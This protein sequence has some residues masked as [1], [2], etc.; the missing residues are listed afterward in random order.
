MTYPS[1]CL[2]RVRSRLEVRL[3][4]RSVSDAHD[5]RMLVCVAPRSHCLRHVT[6]ALMIDRN[7]EG[8]HAR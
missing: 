6:L 8:G 7:D 3:D 1:D 2:M 5:A 4:E